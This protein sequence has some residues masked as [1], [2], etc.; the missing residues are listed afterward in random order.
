MNL[1]QLL[2]LGMDVIPHVPLRIQ[3]SGVITESSASTGRVVDTT[4][5]T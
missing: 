5:T 2:G 1:L 4:D 3:I